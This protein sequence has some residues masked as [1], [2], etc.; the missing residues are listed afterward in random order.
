MPFVTFKSVNG[1]QK[2]LGVPDRRYRAA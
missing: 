1:V 2:E